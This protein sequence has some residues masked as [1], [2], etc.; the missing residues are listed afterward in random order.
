[1]AQKTYRGTAL[2]V[3]FD[4]DACIHAGECVRG[5]PSV[6]DTERRPWV[7]PDGADAAQVREVVGRCPTG[8]LQIVEPAPA[9]SG[10]RADG[11][12]D[13][14][15]VSIRVLPG[16]PLL[17][18]GPFEVLDERGEA[19]DAGAKTALCR[20]GRTAKAPFCDGAHARD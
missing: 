12:A 5:L 16:G 2:D 6:F 11:G 15:A 10:G 19:L 9:D 4:S 18:T 7:L 20:C 1:M 3:T 8:A 14:S 17:V 13:Q